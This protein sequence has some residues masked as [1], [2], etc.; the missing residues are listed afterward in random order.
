V[1]D[2]RVEKFQRLA[3]RESGEVAHGT[4]A[5]CSRH[6]IPMRV[7]AHMNFFDERQQTS[8]MQLGKHLQLIASGAR[9]LLLY[10]G[11]RL[12]QRARSGNSTNTP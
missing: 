6:G 3:V 8:F 12:L 10:G 1:I 9:S 2:F 11:V 5:E 7:C 4:M